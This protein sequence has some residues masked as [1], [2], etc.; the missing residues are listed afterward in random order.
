MKE[1]KFEEAK[2]SMRGFTNIDAKSSIRKIV[3]WKNKEQWQK[4]G[5]YM[6]KYN[7]K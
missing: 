6:I 1:Q 2:F 7:E 4:I 3:E 5:I